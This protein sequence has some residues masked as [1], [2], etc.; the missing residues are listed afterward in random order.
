VTCGN[1][2]TTWM[3]FVNVKSSVLGLGANETS[4]AE[5]DPPACRG[6]ALLRSFQ[7]P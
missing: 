7:M 4:T 1:N 2:Q 3:E 6:M 5:M